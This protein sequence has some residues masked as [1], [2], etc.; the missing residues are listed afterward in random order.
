MAENRYSWV[1]RSSVEGGRYS[2]NS[3]SR[4]VLT[5]TKIATAATAAAGSHSDTEVGPCPSR[6]VDAPC[7]VDASSYYPLELARSHRRPTWLG[8]YLANFCVLPAATSGD[9]DSGRG[10]SIPNRCYCFCRRSSSVALYPVHQLAS[11]PAKPGGRHRR[12]KRAS[13]SILATV[14]HI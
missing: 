14:E 10:S 8:R 13:E 3:A 11:Q 6:D 7:I 2:L 12:R 5:L 1:P 4:R 9:S